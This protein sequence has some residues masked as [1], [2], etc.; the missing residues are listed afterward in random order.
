M[1]LPLFLTVILTL[2]FAP[3]LASAETKVPLGDLIV[4]AVI[5]SNEADINPICRE[6]T[7][8]DG[9]KWVI[10]DVAVSKA[11]VIG[12]MA[13]TFTAGLGCIETART[14][15]DVYNVANAFVER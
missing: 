9:C 11:S 8:T 14:M 3:P 7:K 6:G 12:Q 5:T 13:I 1:R 2:A 10:N 4:G 15:A